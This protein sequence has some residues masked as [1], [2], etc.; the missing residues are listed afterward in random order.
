MQYCYHKG[1]D[2]GG[3]YEHFNRV[4]CWCCPLMTVKN[5]KQLYEHY[6][7]LWEKLQDMDNRAYNQFKSKGVAYYTHKFNKTIN[8][9]E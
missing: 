3:L 9:Q 5:L 1:F 6:P 7:A 8:S 2:W 4:S